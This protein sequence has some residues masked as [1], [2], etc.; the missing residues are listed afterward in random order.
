MLTFFAGTY[1]VLTLIVSWKPTFKDNS[2]PLTDEIPDL[3]QRL[4]GCSLDAL[5]LSN[6][7]PHF[8]KYLYCIENCFRWVQ[9]NIGFFGGDKARVTIFGESAGKI[10]NFIS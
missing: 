8:H 1:L 4:L 5:P 3:N 6:H 10:N 9:D 2:P 7:I